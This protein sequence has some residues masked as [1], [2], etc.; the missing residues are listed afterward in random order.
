[1]PNSSIINC[2]LVMEAIDALSPPLKPMAF[3]L[4]L[5]QFLTQEFPS[6]GPR[7]LY[8]CVSG[9]PSSPLCALSLTNTPQQN[10]MQRKPHAPCVH[11]KY[12]CLK[13]E[14]CLCLG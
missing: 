2:C 14:R 7:S 6:R 11:H 9:S 8:H 4:A 12:I 1:M 3:P 5:P 13:H 10:E